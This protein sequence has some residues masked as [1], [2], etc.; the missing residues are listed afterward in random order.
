MMSKIYADNLARSNSDSSI[1]IA[2]RGVTMQVTGAGP[3]IDCHYCNKFGYY[4]NDCADFQR[5]HQQNQRRRQRQHKQ[6]GG[7]QPY[8]PKPGGA[9][10]VEGRGANVVLI[11][12]DHH[13]R[14]RR[15]LHQAGKQAQRQR[16]LCLSSPSKCS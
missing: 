14:R 15:L 13:P 6:R 12:E 1:G 4:K 7:H 3:N 16:P 10:A 5:V 2:G 8:Q 9:V 11:P